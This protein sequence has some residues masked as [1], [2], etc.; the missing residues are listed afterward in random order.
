[1]VVQK[2]YFSQLANKIWLDV[3]VDLYTNFAI[4][5]GLQ[6]KKSRSSFMNH[7]YDVMTFTVF[8]LD[9]LKAVIIVSD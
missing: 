6:V 5:L 8:M 9:S 7:N 1:M 3:R 4:I 2:L